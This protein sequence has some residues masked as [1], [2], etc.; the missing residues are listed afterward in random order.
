MTMQFKI[1]KASERDLKPSHRSLKDVVELGLERT[2]Y[3]TA[4][5]I[6]E[7]EAIPRESVLKIL[8][9]AQ[10]WPIAKIINR[11]QPSTAHPK[12]KPLGGRPRLA[13]D[14]DSAKTAVL[15]GIEE[16]YGSD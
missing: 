13:F 5:D 11:G 14:P 3:V 7:R 6:S 8:D 1:R 12:G 10:V 2:Q 4:E 15:A 9:G 16:M